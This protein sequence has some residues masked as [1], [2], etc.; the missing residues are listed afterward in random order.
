M[1]EQ[2]MASSAVRQAQSVMSG[3]VFAP[4]TMPVR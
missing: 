1:A 4:R 3:L 2:L